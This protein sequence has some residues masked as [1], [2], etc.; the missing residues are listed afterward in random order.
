ME[1]SLRTECA[2]ARLRVAVGFCCVA[3]ACSAETVETIWNGGEGDWNVPG[4]WSTEAV[5]ASGAGA[6]IGSGAVTISS[7]KTNTTDYVRIGNVAGAGASLTLEADAQLSSKQLHLGL[8]AGSTGTLIQYG[9]LKVTGDTV[10]V[11]SGA[12]STGVWTI[13][14]GTLELGGRALHIGHANNS[15]GRLIQTGGTVTSSGYLCIP[16]G[17]GASGEWLL[18]NG[19]QVLHTGFDSGV[20]MADNTAGIAGTMV[21]ENAG[22]VFST[23]GQFRLGTGTVTVR[24]GGE[25]RA[26]RIGQRI[27]NAQ[28]GKSAVY[29]FDGGKLT[30]HGS[31]S[32]VE[33]IGGFISGYLTNCTHV[34]I[35]NGGMEIQIPAG[36]DCSVA[37]PLEAD[38][39]STGGLTKTGAGILR[40]AANCTYAGQT[41]LQ[42]GVLALDTP[43][44]IDWR[45]K[46]TVASGTT[47]AINP[48][49]WTAAEITAIQALLPADSF[50]GFLVDTVAEIADV[51]TLNPGVGFAKIGNGTLTLTGANNWTGETLLYG[52][53]LRADYGTGIPV[54]SHLRFRGG[55]WAPTG[56][57]TQIPGTGAGQWETDAGFYTRFSA[58][59]APLTINA[60]NDA[61]TLMVG[62][63]PI[64]NYFV[65]N[66]TGA[67][68]S[69]DFRNPMNMTATN[70]DVA[71]NAG[72]A[73]ISGAI[74]G[75]SSRYFGKRNSGTLVLG[76]GITGSPE[77]RI[78][79]GTLVHS[80]VAS[81]AKM[82][83]VYGGTLCVATNLSISGEYNHAAVSGEYGKSIL[84]GG[85]VTCK[86]FSVA[87]LGT[88][89]FVQSGG[90]VVD[91]SGNT[92]I[93]GSYI[94][95]KD[96]TKRGNG[97][98]TLSGGTFTANANFQV[99]VYGI[100]TMTQTGGN[101]NFGG[102]GCVGR[103]APG[104]GTYTLSGGTA[105]STGNY[106][107]IIGEEG[108][109]IVTVCDSGVLDL[110][111]GRLRFGV[112]SS[113]AKGSFILR[114]GGTVKAKWVE[115]NSNNETMD[116]T[117][118]GGTFVATLTPSASQLYFSN[119]T[120]VTIGAG[121]VT[122]DTQN[123][124]I[125]V[126]DFD[127]DTPAF[128]P[129]TKKG[130][131]TLSV[132]S[133]NGFHQVDVQAGTLKLAAAEPV[134]T[135]PLLHRWSF[136]G[137]LEDSVGGQTAT[138]DKASGVTVGE[139]TCT[140]KGGA[141][142]TGAID[143]GP[144]VLPT[145]GTPVTLEMWVTLNT[146]RSWGRIM[147]FGNDTSNRIFMNFS[148][149]NSN[150]ADG[151]ISL[152]TLSGTSGGT[153]YWLSFTKAVAYH[154]GVTFE[155][156][157]NGRWLITVYQQDAAGN[158][159][160]KGSLTA[161]QGW[162]L[163]NLVQT[164]CWLGRSFSSG[165][166]DASATYDE[167]RVWNAVLTEAQLAANAQNG[168]DAELVRP[169]LIT[170]A[171]GSTLDL[172]GQSFS[173][174]ALAGAGTVTNGT[175]A[176]TGTLYPG[177]EN[178]VGTLNLACGGTVTGTIAA[179][180]GDKILAKG[181]LDLSSA[182]LVITDLQNLA[183]VWK[184]VEVTDGT[185]TGNLDDNN[186]SG[187]GWVVQKTERAIFVTRLGLMIMV[188]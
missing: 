82:V 34:L 120:N 153:K 30:A 119:L 173:Q 112:G 107:L 188:R 143:L 176:V 80:N 20:I 63:D 92:M 1:F 43:S 141:Q 122:F 46:L 44:V 87:G 125:S 84:T 177:G 184:L 131:G 85:K 91:S 166:S 28:L 52:G 103:Y 98:M 136:N 79:G 83:K 144:G 182:S 70:L 36:R 139:S 113:K 127:I 111:Q 185:I 101:L 25:L 65:L 99:G 159:I 124:N 66:D 40:I 76:G 151:G 167:V 24:D 71:V 53:T 137:N 60:G 59:G 86:G 39:G 160:N 162:D 142:G 10:E 26:R 67:D 37:Q 174:A 186:L 156:L 118:D 22:T 64:G 183:N 55:T 62:S 56:T 94:D 104:F 97:T 42:E 148:K 161:A 129:L 47:L 4:N 121:G 49:N 2:F 170:L 88:G 57:M 12:D 3:V 16:F 158:T 51:V 157:A 90:S 114:D 73:T 54:T 78:A 133:L 21:I 110:R 5:P 169:A 58:I 150:S 7:G 8:A 15:V 32:Q 96:K 165:D 6:L 41:V 115:R 187:T 50:F 147:N 123:Y 14:S 130:A 19:A 100:G 172:N 23:E 171:S 11:S 164:H 93:G 181:N 29:L 38:A 95:D 9:T 33:F 140:L 106:G 146:Y 69:L 48:A 77:W 178:T 149:N 128:A 109:G 13:A 138:I 155:L 72:T 152:G 74:T 132:G 75:S 27:T 163:G 134:S 81:T 35:G 179:E 126:P 17:S 175:L 168:P 117:V 154:L 145:N 18:S 180:V 108:T 102:W 105:T 135:L 116:M 89:E 31:Q 61:R 68:S 45:N